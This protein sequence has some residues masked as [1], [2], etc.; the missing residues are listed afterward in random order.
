LHLLAPLVSH[1]Q[2]G[3]LRQHFAARSY[4]KASSALKDTV[5]AVCVMLKKCGIPPP[6]RL[7]LHQPRQKSTAAQ[8]APYLKGFRPRNACKRKF[9]N[10]ANLPTQKINRV[11]L[12]VSAR[13]TNL[14][15]S[16]RIITSKG[17]GHSGK[18]RI[19]SVQ[20]SS[21]YP[22]SRPGKTGF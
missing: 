17:P 14:H 7:Q 9:C 2:Q 8:I 11:M 3:G 10:N 20:P 5:A 12:K 18:K 22:T 1:S 13:V 15:A 16:D 19:S 6:T 4:Y 21:Y